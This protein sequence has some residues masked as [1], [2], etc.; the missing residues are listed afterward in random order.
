MLYTGITRDAREI[1]A[2]QSDNLVKNIE[3]LQEI[4][5]LP[6]KANWFDNGNLGELLDENWKLKKQLGPI[7]T[8]QIDEWY[9][10]GLDAGAT[11]GKLLG[12]GG[13]GFLLF[14]C[15]KDTKEKVR[16]ALSNLIEVPI[17]PEPDGAKVILNY[18]T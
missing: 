1:L 15:P 3:I 13:G 18:R 6:Y 5:L 9:K 12:A 2:V 8:P 17:E 16:E 7:S 10:L 4:S 11:G 14:Y